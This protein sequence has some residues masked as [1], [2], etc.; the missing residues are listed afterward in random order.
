[1]SNYFCA[2]N[3]VNDILFRIIAARRKDDL[4]LR[5][6][7]DDLV[8]RNN[9]TTPKIIRLNNV[10][11]NAQQFVLTCLTRTLYVIFFRRVPERHHVNIR[12]VRGIR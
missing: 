2:A 3:W 5:G 7:R 11:T 10:H 8:H 9:T 12:N 6:P 4:L 1:M